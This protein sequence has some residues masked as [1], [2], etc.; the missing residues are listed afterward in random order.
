MLFGSSSKKFV[1]IDFGTRSIKIVEIENSKGEANLVN[2]G[3]VVLDKE[4]DLLE[5][6]Y[7]GDYSNLLKKALGVLLK[8][9]KLSSKKVSVA[10]PAF[11]GLVMVADFPIMTEEELA[12]AI[13][14]ESRK[15]IPASLDDVNVSWEII[16]DSKSEEEGNNGKMKVLLV[17][18]P[19]TEV[20]YYDAL[21]KGTGLEVEL[22]ELETFSLARILSRNFKGENLMLVDVGAKTTNLVLMVNNSVR[23]NRNIDVGGIDLTEAISDNMNISSKRAKEMKESGKN[24]FSGSLALKFPSV[25]YMISEMK[26][27]I[28]LQGIGSLDNII[29]AGGSSEMVGFLDYLQKQLNFP[30]EKADPM[31]YIKSKFKNKSGQLVGLDSS[32]CVAAGLAMHGIDDK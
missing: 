4:K 31:K 22:L 6:K 5:E 7:D 10:I 25:D 3:Q 13:K 2:Y 15:Y 8:K 26:R 19:K 30:V 12:K 16:K 9:M 24:L 29:V 11:N 14:Y 21:L 20:Q 1:G 17:A 32:Y 23:I 18:A 27:M 28:K